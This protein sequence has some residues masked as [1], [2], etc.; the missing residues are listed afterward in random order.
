MYILFNLGEI[1][2]EW[3]KKILM[4][5]KKI[6]FITDKIINLLMTNIYKYMTK[7]YR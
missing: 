1:F 7:E 4:T 3:Q 5:D 2:F 6:I